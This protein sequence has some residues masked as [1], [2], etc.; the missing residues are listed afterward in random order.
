MDFLFLKQLIVSCTKLIP[1]LRLSHKQNPHFITLCKVLNIID[2]H[3]GYTYV[4]PCTA[5]I[6][7][8]GLMDIIPRLIKP[9]VDVPLAI[10]SHQDPLCMSSKFQEWLQVNGV[11]HTVTSTYHPESDG[12]SESKNEEISEMFATAQ[13]Q[14]DHWITAAPDIQA[15]V[16]ARQNKS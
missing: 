13:L 2:R 3:S 1:G 14:G 11:R 16:N 8:D 9:T 7:A 4:I 12:H 5:E 15:K 10:L 6:D